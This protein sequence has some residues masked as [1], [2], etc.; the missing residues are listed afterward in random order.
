MFPKWFCH[1]YCSKVVFTL[2]CDFDASFKKSF[3]CRFPKTLVFYYENGVCRLWALGS[4]Q[5]L[6]PW[7]LVSTSIFNTFQ[8]SN[9]KAIVRKPYLF[10]IIICSFGAKC[11]YQWLCRDSIYC[12]CCIIT[13]CHMF[14]A[15]FAMV[16]KNV[17]HLKT[18]SLWLLPKSVL[19][20]KVFAEP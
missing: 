6:A 10:Y 2:I 7:P 5:S 20:S 13:L 18:G 19:F 9:C 3:S 17:V 4:T 1:N 12:H 16:P 14:P 8:R 15:S 11:F